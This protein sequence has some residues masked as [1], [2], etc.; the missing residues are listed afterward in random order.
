MG[1]LTELVTGRIQIKATLAIVCVVGLLLGVFAYYVAS[2]QYQVIENALLT[3]GRIIALSGARATG[4]MFETAIK[5]RE[6]S[7]K[8]LFD[9][10]Y[11]PI[12][13]TNPQKYH[14]AYD[15]FT[16]KALQRIEDE[17][18]KDTDVVFAAVVDTNGFLPTHNAKYASGAKDVASNRTKRLFNDPV[19]LKAGRH[20]GEVLQQVYKRDTGETM[21]DVSAP[22]Y[23]NG[24]HWGGFR[25]GFSMARVQATIAEN[26]ARIFKAMIGFVLLGAALLIGLASW[27]I[28]RTIVSPIKKIASAATHVVNNSLE[29][30]ATEMQ[31]VSE[32][33]LTRCH[34]GCFDIGDV[35][36]EHKANDE[37]GS[38]A[39]AFNGMLVK[40]EEIGTTFAV[41]L[42]RIRRLV[43]EISESSNQLKR[44]SDSLKEAANQTATATTQIAHTIEQVAQGTSSQSG[45]I[46][47]ILGAVSQMST[48]INQV[49]SDSIRE[50]VGE[51][52]QKISQLSEY[53]AQIGNIVKVIGD[54]A[55]QANLLALNAA[56]EAARAGEH[57]KG[58]AVVADEVRQLAER[59]NSSAGE[60]AQLLTA[61]QK[62]TD[63]TVSAME[64]GAGEV[65]TGTSLAHE[66][67][68]S[69]GKILTTV[70]D[71]DQMIDEIA[72]SVQQV[73]N[74]GD[75]IVTSIESIAAVVAENGAS[76]QEVSAAT[77]Q[78]SAQIQEIVS[79]INDLADMANRLAKDVSYFK[80]A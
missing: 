27:F 15:A 13:G 70:E 61:V 45:S 41:M 43:I 66:A 48:I 12:P 53:S 40:L 9:V 55:A 28:A 20:T 73:A 19:G 50:T 17:Y 22:I 3:K 10:S 65:T 67:G 21:W 42:E 54:I 36:I 37:I 11:K 59:A 80:V 57:G 58:F 4:D 16:D 18:L 31:A 63:Q 25:V 47:G 77:Q 74:K 78:M 38:L 44:A 35:K 79:S 62:G 56:I 52:A 23:V 2:S 5:N 7:E 24:K 51:S 14:T 69:L 26:N 6:I 64:S 71:T 29:S 46:D 75:E 32:G 39:R 76:S 33:D 68:D 49:A 30:F 60:V 1:K 34:T 72:G 8:A